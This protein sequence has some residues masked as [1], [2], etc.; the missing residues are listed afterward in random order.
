MD[1]SVKKVLLR[2]S[3]CENLEVASSR[4]QRK[5]AQKQQNEHNNDWQPQH[6]AFKQVKQHDGDNQK[7]DGQDDYKETGDAVDSLVRADSDVVILR[8]LLGSLW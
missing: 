4:T 2:G 3:S 6:C 7:G 5:G 1:N 8:N